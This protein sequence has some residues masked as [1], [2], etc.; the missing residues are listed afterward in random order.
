MKCQEMPWLKFFVDP[1]R[2]AAKERGATA[3]EKGKPPSNS[4]PL[5][6]GLETQKV[7]VAQRC[8]DG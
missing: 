5:P 4:H 7:T 3:T 1:D 2:G 6:H 8:S